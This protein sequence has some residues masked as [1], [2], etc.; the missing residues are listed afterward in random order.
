MLKFGIITAIDNMTSI[1]VQSINKRSS[2]EIA[3]GR[4]ENGNVI[5]LKAYSKGYSV[6]IR[7][8]INTDEFK[9]EAGQE[10]T[11]GTKKYIIETTDQAENNTGWVEVSLTARTADNAAITTYSA[12]QAQQG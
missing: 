3:E 4:D 2:V 7:A 11:I 8:L 6:D 10:L 1:V 9:T 5:E 12:P